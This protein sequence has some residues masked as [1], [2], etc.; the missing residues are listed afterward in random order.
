[1]PHFMGIKRLCKKRDIL[2]Y[3]SLMSKRLFPHQGALLSVY[4]E[5]QNL[6]KF[7]PHDFLF[8]QITT[9][10]HKNNLDYRQA[11][12]APQALSFYFD[13]ELGKIMSRAKISSMPL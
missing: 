7:Y 1:M 6:L 11:L 9:N 2:A 5:F 13:I 12:Y 10:L 3:I 8:I 4:I